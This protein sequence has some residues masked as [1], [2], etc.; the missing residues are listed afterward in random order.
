[1]KRIFLGVFVLLY[2]L[3][4]CN[5]ATKQ[6][7][8]KETTQ[9]D[10]SGHDHSGDDH[11]HSGH[12]HS[13]D[14]HDHSEHDHSQ[15]DDDHSGH[16]HDE[17]ELGDNEVA[18][19]DEQAK[20]VN[21]TIEKVAPQPFYQIIKTSG[22]LIA[23]VGEESTIVASTSGIV[24]FTGGGL[25]AGTAVNNGQ[26][27]AVVSARNIVDG[28]PVAKSR[29]QYETAKKEFERAE[30]LAKDTLISMADYN[31]AKLNYE[32][33]QV[34]Y[35]ALANQ[36]TGSGVNITSNTQGYIKNLLVSDGEYVSVGQPILTVTK[37]K[38]IQLKADVSEQN[39]GII[40]QITSANFKTANGRESYSIDELNGKLVSYGKLLDGSSFYIPVIFEFNN[41]GH[42]LTGAFVTVYLKTRT[43]EQAIT[44]PLTAIIEEQGLFFVYV[45][46]REHIYKKKEIKKGADDG[47]RALILSGLASGEELVA[48]S[49]YHL[50]LASMSSAIPHGHSH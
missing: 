8:N 7:D 15:D 19:S 31:Q 50:K 25:N 10:H 28:D 29:L 38:R 27:I 6:S 44:A 12:D 48:T 5:S 46:D 3:S 14:D 2:L 35:N 41:T 34:A 26:R 16:D 39:A 17:E 13:L 30:L 47:K 24:K 4:A 33:A 36:S 49:A 23:P 21:L 40:S 37:N 43:I 20:R 11:D 45:K 42:F 1:M 32:N 18:F 9:S 22:Q